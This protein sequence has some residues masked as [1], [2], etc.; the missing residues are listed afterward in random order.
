MK[1]C[2]F[3]GKDLPIDERSPY[4][5]Y[6]SR[7]CSRRFRFGEPKESDKL[8]AK[9]IWETRK[10]NGNVQGWNKGKKRL[11]S[12][13]ENNYFWK[14]GGLIYLR[15]RAKARDNYTCQHC[16]LKSEMKGFMDVDHIKPIARNPELRLEL[17]NMIT[18]CPNC[19]RIKSMKERKEYKMY[20]P[21]IVLTPA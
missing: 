20:K 5:K 6:C 1:N 9:K 10:R 16:G 17:T 21:K 13:G 4:R 12:I 7:L 3:C 15:N 8:R 18:L 14:G 2:L 11:H 19:H